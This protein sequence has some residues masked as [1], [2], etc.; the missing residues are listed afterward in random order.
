MSQK[1][2]PRRGKG[3]RYVSIGHLYDILVSLKDFTRK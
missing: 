1:A 2:P 3:P